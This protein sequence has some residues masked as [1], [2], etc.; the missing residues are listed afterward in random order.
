MGKVDLDKKISLLDWGII[1]ST[2]IMLAV[3]YIPQIIWNE[4]DVYKAES[5]HRMSVISN[6]Q[7]FY[8]EMTGDFTSDGKLLF[9]LVEAAMDS[10][11]ADS[12]FLGEKLINLKEGNSILVNIEDGFGD[13]V[14]TTFSFA[15]PIKKTKLDTIYTVGIINYETK[16]VDTLFVNAKDINLFLSD[17]SFYAIFTSDTVTRSERS[18]DYL[19]KKYHLDYKLLKCPVTDSPYIFSIEGSEEKSFS[20]KSPLP[21]DYSERRFIFFKF[22]PRNHG[23]IISGVKSWAE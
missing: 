3:V 15:V 14:D 13:K 17:S 1:F 18:T 19:R 2:L 10:S 9:D 23:S 11:L 21:N 6:A 8:Y 20:I 5:R 7:E 12:L 4:E 22:K 16:G